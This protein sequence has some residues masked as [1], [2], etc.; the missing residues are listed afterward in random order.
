LASHGPVVLLNG[1]EVGEEAQGATGFQ[2][3]N[4]KST[5]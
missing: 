4:G 3:D 5:I 2:Q 1:Q